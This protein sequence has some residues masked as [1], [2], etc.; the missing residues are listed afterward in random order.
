MSEQA[1]RWRDP[2]GAARVRASV[3]F[4]APVDRT[5]GEASLRHPGDVVRLV[6]GAAVVAVSASVAAGGHVS[7]LEADVFRLFNDL[8]AA[9]SPPLQVVMQAGALGAVGVV[10]A[11]G[12]IAGRRR[13]ARDAALSG[14]AAWIAVKVVKALVGRG[15]PGGVLGAVML[16]GVPAGGLGFPSGHAA[17]AAALATAAGPYLSRRARRLTWAGVALVSVARLNVGAHLPLDVLGGVGLGWAVGA[18][19]HLLWGA[20]GGRPSLEDVRQA[21]VDGG[22]GARAVA[23][24]SVD[25]RGSTP[26]FAVGKDGRALFVKVVGPE[27]RD[28]DWLFKAWRWVAYREL[29][30]EAPFATGKQLIEHEAYLS[31]LASRAGVRTPVIV[32]TA[33]MADGSA[34]LVTERVHGCRLGHPDEPPPG[35]DVLHAVW[36]EVAKLHAVRIAHR[37]LRLANLV[38]DPAGRP[39][40]MDFGFAQSVASPRR[41]AQDRAELLASLATVTGPERAV[42][43]AGEVLGPE[44]LGLALPLLQPMAL[45]AATRRQVRRR[46]HLLADLRGAV[47]RATGI[48]MDAAVPEPLTRVR[49]RSVAAL[50]VAA[51]AVHV[52]VPQA[53]ELRHTLDALQGAR[54]AWLVP[55]A[56]I[57][58]LTYV[59]AAFAMTAA[60]GL[61]LPL[62]R[63]T[64]VQLASSVANRLAPGGLGGAATNVRYLQRSGLDRTQAVTAVGLTSAV[65]ARRPRSRPGG[66]GRGR[67]QH[68]RDP[69]PTAPSLDGAGRGRR[70]AGGGGAA[71]VDPHGPP[72]APPRPGDYGTRPPRPAARTP[73]GRPAV[74][75]RRLR[76]GRLR[77]RPGRLAARLRGARVPAHRCRRVPRR[78]GRRLGQPHSGRA[79]RRGSR[80]R[81]RAH[82]SGR[83]RR[84]R[85]RG[86]ARLPACHLLAPHPP[87]RPRRARSPAPPGALT[88]VRSR[89]SGRR[90]VLE[91]PGV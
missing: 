52:L 50:L 14:T 84:A 9:L 72:A 67:G 69:P 71:A 33:S 22:L 55:A 5:R 20:P 68:G 54:W 12:L 42:T 49:L 82:S 2:G 57:S 26:F 88:T 79:G 28:A 23:P 24:A 78:C 48:D 21:L 85:Y 80:P 3:R 40:V 46:P 87:R 10:G 30:D 64:L 62:G 7:R 32:T 25:A 75:R 56:A 83:G 39:W 15:R 17:V 16:R 29:E 61:P 63:T 31:L 4:A 74:P 73:A 13:L 19:V 27:Q 81:R 86:R 91:P 66:P 51:L 38:V 41:L 6:S 70:G 1:T 11:L 45:T 44:A 18:A 37:D 43:T 36:E 35:D 90:T 59:M 76:D 8:P 58:A 77:P 60:S 65:G 34:V 89:C 53:A 47:A